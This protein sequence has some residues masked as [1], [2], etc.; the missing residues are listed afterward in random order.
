MFLNTL[1]ES[2]LF[3]LVLDQTD[4]ESVQRVMQVNRLYAFTHARILGPYIEKRQLNANATVVQKFWRHCGRFMT[5]SKISRI[6]IA[7]A[8]MTDA[9]MRLMSFEEMLNF[10]KEPG[11][12]HASRRFMERALK[13]SVIISSVPVHA[14]T[15]N[16]RVF[17]ASFLAIYFTMNVFAKMEPKEQRVLDSAGLLIACIFDMSAR[18][19]GGACFSQLPKDLVASL[20]TLMNAYEAAFAIWKPADLDSLCVR[21]VDAWLCLFF[22]KRQAFPELMM[23][24]EINTQ[25]E[26][27]REKYLKFKGQAALDIIE[28]FMVHVEEIEDVND[29]MPFFEI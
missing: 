28:R 23:D 19:A 14:N 24:D 4:I 27:M 17:L 7:K 25:I 12:I 8:R 21:I 15:R 6:F 18:L 26:R 13:A 2:N 29:N 11:T 10:L 16:I 22:A 9:D 5:S 1:M 20:P 3:T